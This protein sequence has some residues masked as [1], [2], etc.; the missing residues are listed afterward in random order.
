MNEAVL[1]YLQLD[2]WYLLQIL[3]CILRSYLHVVHEFSICSLQ[4]RERDNF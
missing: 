4:Q 2:V 1:I 3:L